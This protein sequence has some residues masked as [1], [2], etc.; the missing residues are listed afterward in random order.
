[1]DVAFD[2]R[3]VTSSR[4][5]LEHAFEQLERTL[6]AQLRAHVHD[7]RGLAEAVSAVPAGVLTTRLADARTQT[8]A[9]PSHPGV[10]RPFFS[11]PSRAGSV[12]SLPAPVLQTNRVIQRQPFFGS[13]PRTGFLRGAPFGGVEDPL[14][15]PIIDRY[16]RETGLRPD[17]GPSDAMLK[18]VLVFA[19]QPLAVSQR[20]ALSRLL[21]AFT[22]A[23]DADAWRVTIQQVGITLEDHLR[24][25]GRIS[26]DDNIIFAARFI[27]GRT[28]RRSPQDR[29]ETITA[30]IYLDMLGRPDLAAR[31]R[32]ASSTSNPASRPRTQ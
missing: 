8:N 1:M 17:E 31:L 26:S 30:G 11:G 14:H 19:N 9:K 18:Y 15:Q 7:Q 5:C 25:E 16:R 10:V 13:A 32:R 2:P 28:F 6:E 20:I 23:D 24:R 21:S 3:P 12:L 29:P 22:I 27:I 4:E